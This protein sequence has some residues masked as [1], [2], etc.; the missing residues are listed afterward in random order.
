MLLEILCPLHVHRL[1][2]HGR[3]GVGLAKSFFFQKKQFL[4]GLQYVH[5][6]LQVKRD[7][8]TKISAILVLLAKQSSLTRCIYIETFELVH[9]ELH[10]ATG[11]K[12]F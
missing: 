11:P 9:V 4:C 1:V 3:G 5:T 7:P 6:T 2:I 12:K 8:R 10:H